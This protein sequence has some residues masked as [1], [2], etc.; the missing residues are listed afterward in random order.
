MLMDAK[1]IKGFQGTGCMYHG[2]WRFEMPMIA[3]LMSY[4]GLQARLPLAIVE[5]WHVD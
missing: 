2:E 5:R 1:L 3:C 4:L